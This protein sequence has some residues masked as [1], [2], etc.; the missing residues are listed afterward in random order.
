MK[1]TRKSTVNRANNHG[2]MKTTIPSHIVA[3]MELSDKDKLEWSAELI[4][5]DLT[6]TLKKL[7]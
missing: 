3:M 4:K 1:V 6:V 2:S 5:D 7:E